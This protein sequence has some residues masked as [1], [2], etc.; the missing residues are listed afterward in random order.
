MRIFFRYDLENFVEIC[1]I[2]SID[3]N[4]PLIQAYDTK[5]K[6]MTLHFLEIHK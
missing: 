1:K 4:I 6:N 3:S 5:F 2:K